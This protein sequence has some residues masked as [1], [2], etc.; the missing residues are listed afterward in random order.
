MT[1]SKVWSGNYSWLCIATVRWSEWE[2]FISST[3]PCIVAHERV[4][5][6][7]RCSGQTQRDS[8]NNVR[9]EKAKVAFGLKRGSAFSLFL[10]LFHVKLCAVFLCFS[11]SHSLST[12]CSLCWLKQPLFMYSDFIHLFESNEGKK[13]KMCLHFI[14]NLPFFF[15]SCTLRSR[16]EENSWYWR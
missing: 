10:F 1:N 9:K 16:S 13:R 8:E 14:N 3:L 12:R 15:H 7:E 2:K 5:E 4:S 11:V 6:A